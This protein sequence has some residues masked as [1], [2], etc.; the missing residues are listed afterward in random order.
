[1][2]CG[3]TCGCV[4]SGSASGGVIT[5]GPGDYS[6]SEDCWF[7]ISGDNPTATFT[8]LQT[9]VQNAA[10]GDWLFVE[11]SEDAGFEKNVIQ[12]AKL[13]GSPTLRSFTAT[14]GRHLRLRLTSDVFTDVDTATYGFPRGFVATWSIEACTACGAGTFK[15]ATGPFN[16]TRCPA[17]MTSAEGSVGVAACACAAGSAIADGA[18][19]CALCDAGWVCPGDGNATR[20]CDAGT[21]APPG[22]AQC[23]SCPAN[24]TSGA[25]A[26]SL[27]S[28]ACLGGFSGSPGASECEPCPPGSF[29]PG[30]GN[31]SCEVC[32]AETSSDAGSTSRED[33]ICT[34]GAYGEA[35]GPCS[36]CQE[37]ASSVPGS[38]TVTDCR[39]KAGFYG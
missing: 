31:S 15:N 22:A 3:G 38:D 36:L 24:A 26:T 16:C 9:Q 39:C 5:D 23:S 21:Y 28:C 10:G 1:M 27:A 13:Q 34:A 35:G 30:V 8:F 17:Q 14:A 18:S 25:G 11:E 29:K 19:E 4:G 2:R 12:L 20:K 37:H 33:C 7:I 6:D 32:A